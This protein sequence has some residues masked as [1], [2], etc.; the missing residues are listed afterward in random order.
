MDNKSLCSTCKN[1][2][3]FSVENAPG[4][5]GDRTIVKCLIDQ[6]AFSNLVAGMYE[7]TKPYP[8]VYECSHYQSKK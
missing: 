5:S 2:F 4:G 1:C 7:K 6:E 8:N 3:C